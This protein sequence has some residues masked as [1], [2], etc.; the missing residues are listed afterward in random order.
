MVSKKRNLEDNTSPKAKKPKLAAEVSP[1]K[2]QK[3]IKAKVKAD[4]PLETAS[5]V[6]PGEIDFPR[7][8]GTTLT[9]QEVK[10][11]RVEAMTEA[12]DLFKVRNQYAVSIF[13][14][15]YA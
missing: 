9:P 7:G 3:K 4:K 5:N 8:G 10:A 6:V 2:K 15:L 12:D 11:I 1:D 13:S 14:R